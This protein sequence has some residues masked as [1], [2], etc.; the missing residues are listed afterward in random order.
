MSKKTRILFKAFANGFIVMAVAGAVG[1]LS[2]SQLKKNAHAIVEDTLPGLSD[3]GAAN[4]Y[5]GDA[6]RTLLL[7]VT[8]D[9]A[10]R[11]E[12][13]GEIN[14]LAGR[15]TTYLK[16]Y[17]QSIYSSVDRTNFQALVDERAN[18]TKVRDSVIALALAGQKDEALSNYVEV[19]LPAHKR[20]KLAGDRLFEYNMQVGADR[21]RRIMT[22]CTITQIGLTVGTVL[23]FMVGFF[24]GLF[25]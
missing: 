25:K 24:I 15:T 13:V 17:D 8:E 21:G 2:L 5:L 14:T 4:A 9:P 12:I 3:A 16:D 11:Q 18:Y 19:M 23:I 1:Y 10:K 22:L 20:L 7:I 6:S